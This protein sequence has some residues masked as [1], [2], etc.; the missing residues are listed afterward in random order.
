MSIR[1]IPAQHLLGCDRCPTE[2]VV[3]SP[4]APSPPDWAVIE[5]DHADRKTFFALCPYCVSAFT[6]LFGKATPE[7]L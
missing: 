3:P 6:A 1:T 5:M 4:E 2:R 7:A